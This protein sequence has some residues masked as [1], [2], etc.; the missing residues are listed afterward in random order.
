M[1]GKVISL[2]SLL[3]LIDQSSPST[4]SLGQH[5][6]TV[7][8]DSPVDPHLDCASIVEALRKLT[9][10]LQRPQGSAL[11]QIIDTVGLPIPSIVAYPLYDAVVIVSKRF[12]M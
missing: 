9:L 6:R 5:I 8:V 11:R 10:L 7:Q 4:I 3:S 12:T 2:P 1:W